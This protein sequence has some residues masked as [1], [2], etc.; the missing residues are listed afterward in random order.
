VILFTSGTS[1]RPKGVVLNYREHL[2]NIDPAADGFGV[3]ATTGVR[4][5][6]LQLGVGA[7]AGRAGAGQP[8]RHPG[9]DGKILAS[10]FFQHVR[11]HRRDDRRR[12]SDHRS[13]SCST[14][15]PTA[16]QDNLP[17]LRFITVR[18]RRRSPIEECA[19]SRRASD[20]DRAG[21]RLQ[22]TGW[23]AAVPGEHRRLGTV[24]AAAAYH[25]LAVVDTR[26]RQLP[27]GQIGQVEIGGFEIG[28]H[29][30]HDYRYLAD[31]GSVKTGSRGRIRTGD[32]GLLDAD[33]FLS[34]T[35][36]EKDLIIRG[37]VNISPI[38]IDGFL[39]QHPELIE[40]AT[41]GVPDAIYGEEVVS[42]V[43]ARPGATIDTASSCAIAAKGCR[44][45]RRRSRSCSA[46]RCRRPSAASS[47]GVRWRNCGGTKRKIEATSENVSS[48]RKRGPIV[49]CTPVYWNVWVPAWRWD[50]S[51][52]R[53]FIIPVRASECPQPTT[54]RL[55]VGDVL[56]A[57]E[58]LGLDPVDRDRPGAG[59]RSRS[60]TA[61]VASMP[62]P[63]LETGVRG[64]ST[65]S[66]RGHALGRHEGLAAPA[67]D[68]IEDVG[69]RI[70][71][72]VRHHMTSS[73]E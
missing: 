12:Q 53:R 17:T 46:S 58:V 31:D 40:V 16:Q 10:R 72:V 19:G 33:G 7:A 63:P 51:A 60:R 23:I 39:M 30:S 35:G 38:E 4:F 57:E 71:R 47:T 73:M 36:R 32:L 2:G 67:R 6:L 62:M 68:R 20:P 21:L 8:R 14:P 26:R 43:V 11:D 42:Y 9:H 55:R 61:P 28:G 18:A 3:T 24:G 48:Q 34:L 49:P 27:P 15:R 65:A 50:D 22:R 13:T 59:S 37:G 64:R 5:P 45:S 44:H 56:L 69:A 25:R 41:V 1:A 66:R 70:T 54:A 29:A 52:G